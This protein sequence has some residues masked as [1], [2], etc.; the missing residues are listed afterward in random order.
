MKIYLF[1]GDDITLQ[2]LEK[3]GKV[4][5]KHQQGRDTRQ[6]MF[7]I[8]KLKITVKQPM[9]LSSQLLDMRATCVLLKADVLSRDRNA[10]IS[11]AF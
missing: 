7:K 11:P 5:N 3:A 4:K 1:L 9:D 2:V 6:L 8:H 10:G